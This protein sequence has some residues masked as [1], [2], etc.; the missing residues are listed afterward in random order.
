MRGPLAGTSA[1]AD[2]DS[3]ASGVP[4]CQPSVN[5]GG[6]GRSRASPSSEPP[7]THA[8]IV[9][10]SWSERRRLLANSPNAGSAPH[11][12]IAR[13]MTALR[14]ALAH[15]R[16]S[17]TL[18]SDIGAISP[19]RWHDAQFLLKMGAMS[20]LKVT[21]ACARGIAG[22][23]RSATM[24]RPPRTRPRDRPVML[25][26]LTECAA[27]TRHRVLNVRDFDNQ[28]LVSLVV[29]RHDDRAGEIVHVP[30]DH[31]AVIVER[32]HGEQPGNVGADQLE[33]VP[34][35][36]DLP[37]IRFDAGDVGQGDFDLTSKRPQLVQ[38]L[39]VEHRAIALNRDV[40]HDLTAAPSAPRAA[41]RRCPSNR[42]Y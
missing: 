33:P 14:I 11:G 12:G 6:A 24:P 19:A 4:M 23:A 39:D 42:V 41:R 15:G 40:N 10:S 36:A 25:M 35:A 22:V 8:A 26:L 32:A 27:K 38:P 16:A 29:E 18:V 20:L 34:P 17:L 3:T 9:A 21:G 37:G 2:I 31:L 13:S 7:P 28:L 1:G 30:E 5:T